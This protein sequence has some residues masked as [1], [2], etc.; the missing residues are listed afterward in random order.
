MWLRNFLESLAIRQLLFKVTNY[1]TDLPFTCYLKKVNVIQPCTLQISLN[2][3][4]GHFISKLAFEIQ[5]K[6]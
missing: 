4:K 1:C 5:W 3:N 2:V 6:I